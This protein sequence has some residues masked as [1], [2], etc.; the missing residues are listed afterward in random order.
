MLDEFKRI[1]V[2]VDRLGK[3]NFG[4]GGNDIGALT[5]NKG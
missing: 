5:R 3:V 4:K 2:V 1:K